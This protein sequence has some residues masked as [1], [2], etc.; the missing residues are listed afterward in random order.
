MAKQFYQ[1]VA[2]TP[3][4][5]VVWDDPQNLTDQATLQAQVDA[6]TPFQS[7]SDGARTLLAQG[8]VP[9]AGIP[10]GFP[11]LQSFDDFLND[12]IERIQDIIDYYGYSAKQ[13]TIANV[14]DGADYT[15]IAIESFSAETV[16]FEAA[17]SIDGDN[18]TGWQPGAQP[19]SI[20]YRVRD[21]RKNIEAIKLW[22][23]NNTLRTYLQGLTV[24]AAQ[25]LSQI[26]DPGNIVVNSVNL[27]HTPGQALQTVTFDFKKR[28][29]YVKLDIDGSAHAQN[30][31]E[32][33]TFLARV[34]TFGH[35]K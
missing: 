11:D 29:R 19:A 5:I 4:T 2:G 33:R 12:E 30:E 20:T 34:T 31:I 26:D 25:S 1:L 27:A 14:R 35:D 10:G 13:E 3:D 28:A 17:N 18:G 9:G 15:P 22:I 8:G 24:R 23:P 16:G 21:H 6:L 32:I 7:L